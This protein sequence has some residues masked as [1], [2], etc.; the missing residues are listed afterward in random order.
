[1]LTEN[2]RLAHANL[3]NIFYFAHDSHAF[4]AQK[5][6]FFFKIASLWYKI[7]KFS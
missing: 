5:R 1:M 4:F 7:I 2:T 6:H 3:S